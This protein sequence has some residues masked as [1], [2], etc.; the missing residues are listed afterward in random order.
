[1][2]VFESG[3]S[4]SCRDVRSRVHEGKFVL[5]KSALD[6]VNGSMQH[7][8]DCMPHTSNVL[9]RIDN[10]PTA[11]ELTIDKPISIMSAAGGV[12]LNCP[13]GGIKIRWVERLLFPDFILQLPMNLGHVK[14]PEKLVCMTACC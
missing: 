12:K 3:S 8:L 7:I 2:L 1:M 6:A 13:Q 5:D 10:I 4:P 9:L 14:L 11:V